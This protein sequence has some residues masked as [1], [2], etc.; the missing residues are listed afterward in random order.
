MSKE[1]LTDESWDGLLGKYLKA[2]DLKDDKGKIPCINIKVGNEEDGS[3]L[4]EAI[5]EVKG[6]P[7]TW[8][9]NMTNRQKL[10]ELGLAKPRDLIG[11]LIGYKKITVTNPTTKKE[12][13]GLRIESFE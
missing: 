11:K 1:Q 9:L 8:S 13:P 5:V 7:K 12:V 4:F 10:K 6:M 3:P 2:E